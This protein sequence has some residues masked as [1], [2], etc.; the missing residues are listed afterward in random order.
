MKIL[1][2]LLLTIML[3]GCSVVGIALTVAGTAA[4]IATDVITSPFD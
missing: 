4:G 2:V 3:S 1:N